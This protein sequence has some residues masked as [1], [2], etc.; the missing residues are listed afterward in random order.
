[1]NR[2]LPYLNFCGVA[3]LGLLCVVQWQTNRRISLDRIALERQNRDLA[4]Q[5]ARQSKSIQ[6]LN[7]DLGVFREQLARTSALARQADSSQRTLQREN[8][9]LTAER[10]Q[11]KTDLASWTEALAA[12]DRHLA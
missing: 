8:G 12:R 7:A 3:I 6:D 1:M 2:L 4:A 10:D 9:Q 11:L 5:T